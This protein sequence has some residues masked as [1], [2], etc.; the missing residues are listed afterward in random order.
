MITIDVKKAG[1]LD[2]ALK[3]YKYKVNK[4]KMVDELRERKEFKK[5]SVKRRDEILKAKYVQSK[6][7]EELN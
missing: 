4:T 6:K 3:T 7:Q 5:K 2:R 1:S